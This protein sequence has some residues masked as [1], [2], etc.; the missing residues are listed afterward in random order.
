LLGTVVYDS[1]SGSQ[2]C[3]EFTGLIEVDQVIVVADM[4]PAN[5][6]LRNATSASQFD[7][8]IQFT[9]GAV[10]PNRGQ[11]VYAFTG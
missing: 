8:P 1:N 10:D 5:Q 9:R 3:I 7:Q 2:Q 11:W 4:A 6:Q